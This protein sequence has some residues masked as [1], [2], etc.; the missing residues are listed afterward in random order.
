MD[1]VGL[2][3]YMIILE[4]YKRWTIYD[5]ADTGLLAPQWP[6][7]NCDGDHGVDAAERAATK[8]LDPQFPSV[9]QLP[10]EAELHARPRTV[11]VGPGDCIFVPGFSP[12][13]VENLTSSVAIAGNFV[14]TSNLVDVRAELTALSRGGRADSAQLLHALDEMEFH[15]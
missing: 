9:M 14:H 15:L 10:V 1:T 4:G 6:N 11:V 7:A 3:F 8:K 12:H 13:V 2:H 5:R